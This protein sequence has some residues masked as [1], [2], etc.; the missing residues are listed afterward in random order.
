ML[1]DWTLFPAQEC[2]SFYLRSERAFFVDIQHHVADVSTVDG[3]DSGLTKKQ[4]LATFG[5]DADDVNQIGGVVKHPFS[6]WSL[7]GELKANESCFGMCNAAARWATQALLPILKCILSCPQA[8]LPAL[9][10]ASLQSPFAIIDLSL[11]GGCTAKEP[12][13]AGSLLLTGSLHWSVCWLDT[14]SGI[15]LLSAVYFRGRTHTH[16]HRTGQNRRTCI[17]V[18]EHAL[19]CFFL[20][21]AQSHSHLFS[22]IKLDISKWAEGLVL[23]Y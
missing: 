10:P 19:S 6:F 13:R 5:F 7:T 8:I 18:D 14:S 3:S 12:E 16:T 2:K 9:I 23:I 22:G 11:H 17:S 20:S 21:F 4:E 15:W 1:G